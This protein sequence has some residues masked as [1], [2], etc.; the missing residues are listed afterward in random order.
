MI[1]MQRIETVKEIFKRLMSI[2][3]QYD[4]TLSN[5]VYDDYVATL[6]SADLAQL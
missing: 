2:G 4:M 5:D 6:G 3:V 1:V